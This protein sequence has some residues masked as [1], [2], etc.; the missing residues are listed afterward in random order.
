MIHEFSF[1]AH[2]MAHRWIM[3]ENK[4][5]LEENRLGKPKKNFHSEKSHSQR[6]R[7]FQSEQKKIKKKIVKKRMMRLMKSE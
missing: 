1:R 3:G 6:L 5:E 2:D 7:A 4:N